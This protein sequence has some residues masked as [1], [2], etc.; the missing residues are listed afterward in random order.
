MQTTGILALK[1]QTSKKK[2]SGFTLIEILIVMALV[3]IIMT[4]VVPNATLALKMNIQNSARELASTIRST[5][6]ES[7]LKGRVHRM[8]FDLSNGEYWVEIGEKDFLMRTEE[9]EEEETRRQERISFKKDKKPESPFA[10]VTSKS[11]LRRG[12]KK[13]PTGVV[14]KDIMTSRSKAALTEGLVYAHFF[15]HGFVEKLV[16]HVKDRF[17]RES[18]VLVN[19]IT[20]KSKV[21]ERYVSELQ[22]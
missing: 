17:G 19:P 10:M 7:I 20:G 11:A 4:L 22:E 14:F 12:K 2:K 21:Y 8:V 5:Y 18:S 15:P 13:L 3:A 1:T 9:Q 16:V 6:D